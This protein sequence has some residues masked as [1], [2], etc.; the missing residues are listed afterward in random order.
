M[1]A[2]WVITFYLNVLFNLIFLIVTSVAIPNMEIAIIPK[3]IKNL[4]EQH[5][6][7]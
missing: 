3:M 5:N 2:V 6:K 7:K 4:T 1:E